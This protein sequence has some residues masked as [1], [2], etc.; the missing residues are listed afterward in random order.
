MGGGLYR[1]ESRPGRLSAE[2]SQ[3]KAATDALERG[4]QSLPRQSLPTSRFI[5][6]SSPTNGHAVEVPLPVHK[7]YFEQLLE[8]VPEAI[9]ILVDQ[10]SNIVR[11]NREFTR[12]FGYTAAEAI[13]KTARPSDR[14]PRSLCGNRVDHRDHQDA[15]QGF[16]GDSPPRKDGSLVEV[17]LSTSPVKVNGERIGSYASYRDITEQKRAEELNAAFYAIAARSQSAEDLQQ[18]FAAIHNIVGQLMNARNF[19]IALY[20]P[21]VSAPDFPYFV[22]EQDSVPLPSGSAAALPNTSCA[23]ASPCWRRRAYLRNWCAAVKWN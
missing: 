1:G 5:P 23:R 21:Q 18:F 11:I 12:L 9:S 20:D 7:A 14:S 16:A 2:M 8:N 15:K 6:V 19:Y 13:G 4:A 17:L 3:V 22:D 10:E